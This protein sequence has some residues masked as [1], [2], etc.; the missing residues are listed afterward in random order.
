MW[1]NAQICTAVAITV[2]ERRGEEVL[3]QRWVLKA[4]L[5]QDLLFE[6]QRRIGTSWDDS[7]GTEVVARS[8]RQHCGQVKN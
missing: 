6:S 8:V 5:N 4:Q 3:G 1:K 7:V 2:N